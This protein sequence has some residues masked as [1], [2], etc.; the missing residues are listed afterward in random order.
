M[1][2]SPA[3]ERLRSSRLVPLTPQT[4]LPLDVGFGRAGRCPCA[5]VA[6]VAVAATGGCV[7]VT[8]PGR[9]NAGGRNSPGLSRN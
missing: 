3:V 2:S 5:A 9:T 8:V 1:L 6:V 7:T 4:N